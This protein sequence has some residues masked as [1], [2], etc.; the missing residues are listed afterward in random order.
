[1]RSDAPAT[2]PDAAF[3]YPAALSLTRYLETQRGFDLLVSLLSR[4]GEGE[5]LDDAFLALYGSRYNEL[6]A[7]WAGSLRRDDAP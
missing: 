2:W 6:A 1:V 7:A 4:L 3:S 5:R